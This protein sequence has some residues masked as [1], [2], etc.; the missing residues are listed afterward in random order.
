MTISTVA[1]MEAQIELD[2]LNLVGM[3]VDDAVA[4]LR[5]TYKNFDIKVAE[6]SAKARVGV[7]DNT[8]IWVWISSESYR[9][10]ALVH[11]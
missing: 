11:Q 5:E 8:T 2:D 10:T 1:L 3:F 9:V 7:I 6:P 4:I